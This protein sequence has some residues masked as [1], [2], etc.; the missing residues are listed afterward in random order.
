M[1]QLVNEYPN[2]TWKK[3]FQERLP[4]MLG[5]TPKRRIENGK[6]RTTYEESCRVLENLKK[7]SFH[8]TAV[9]ITIPGHTL[10]YFQA[11]YQRLYACYT[12]GQVSLWEKKGIFQ[13]LLNLPATGAP[14]YNIESTEDYLTV[15]F[16]D[17]Q[18]EIWRKDQNDQLHWLQ[19]EKVGIL[20]TIFATSDI[21]F[22]QAGSDQPLCLWKRSNQG[23]FQIIQTIE[24]VQ[25]LIF[26]DDFF[27]VWIEGV[28][29]EVRS[30]ERL[31]K[32]FWVENPQFWLAGP[33]FC[34]YTEDGLEIWKKIGEKLMKQA[35]LPLKQ[36]ISDICIWENYLCI[37][38]YKHHMLLL[39]EIFNKFNLARTLW[40][41]ANY[42]VCNGVL[43]AENKNGQTLD[44]WQKQGLFVHKV[45]TIFLQGCLTELILYHQT[46]FIILNDTIIQM[47][48]R[49]QGALTFKK[50][51]DLR[52]DRE[53][54]E[55]LLFKGGCLIA[56]TVEEKVEI[57]DFTPK[58]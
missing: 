21:L 1:R 29:L 44:V 47:F 36:E 58:T 7:A 20:T 11:G 6:A 37:Q 12:H 45:Q 18:L 2:Y 22:T 46:L 57:W 27:A 35:V 51:K 17:G 4:W 16:E 56:Q 13:H 3:L 32:T 5:E 9:D 48:G 55:D 26:M 30:E 34:L 53:K 15:A 43:F 31:L 40:T 54:I 19:K 39:F 24:R 50:L 52:T 25:K 8:F 14:V 41:Y 33:Y 28:G 10:C 49:E 23:L 38:Y 42:Y